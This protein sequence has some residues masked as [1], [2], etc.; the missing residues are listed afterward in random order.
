MRPIIPPPIL[1]VIHAAAMVFVARRFDIAPF[2]F[3][4]DAFAA[5]AVFALGAVIIAVSVS[6]FWRAKTTINPLAPAKAEKLVVRG[7]YTVSRNPM[8]LGMALMLVGVCLFLREG[9]NVG[10]VLLFVILM[11]LMQIEPEERALEAKFGKDYLDYKRRVR[12]WI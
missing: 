11:N 1:T 12:R 4:G 10:V 6:S 7:F 5:G 2:S 8:Y 9:A 3:S